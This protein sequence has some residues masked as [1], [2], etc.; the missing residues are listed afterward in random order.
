MGEFFMQ[1]PQTQKPKNKLKTFLGK[2]VL[3]L[4]QKIYE[5]LN[6]ASTK[7]TK[8]SSAIQEVKKLEDPLKEIVRDVVDIL[9]YA[10]A[11]VATYE[12]GDAL[13]VRAFYINP[14]LGGGVTEDKIREWERQVSEFTPKQISLTNPEIARVYPHKEDHKDNLSVIAYNSGNLEISDNLFSLFTPITPK[15][16][17][18]LIN[19]IQQ[20]LGIEQVIAVP[21]FLNTEINGKVE[22]EFIGNLFAAKQDPISIEDQKILSSFA[23]YAALS[24]LS[25]RQ[26]LQV[27]IVEDLI[28]DI[29]KNLT[30]EKRVLKR[31][32]QGIVEEMGY[33]GAMVATYESGDAL[34]VQAM[35]INA[36]IGEIA[37]EDKIKEWEIQVSEFASKPIS[38]TDPEIARVYPHQDEYKGNLSVIAY[39][40]KKPEISDN[41]FSLFTP[42]TPKESE[43][44]INVIQQTLGIKQVIAVPFFLETETSEGIEK[45]FVGNLF[46]LSKS[47]RVSSW[48]IKLLE[49]FGQ[50]AAA[51]LR[52]V[53][54]YHETRELY[55]KA[56]DRRKAAEIFGKMAFTASASVHALKNHMG[57]INGT[58]QIVKETLDG[59]NKDMTNAAIKRM[60]EMTLLVN[61]LHEPWKFQ[62]ETGTDVN[63]C[64]NRATERSLGVDVPW[65]QKNLSSNPLLVKTIPEMLTEAFRVLIK[66]ANEAMSKFPER[67]SLEIESKLIDR[68]IEVIIKDHGEGIA[69]E[70]IFKIFEMRFTTKEESGLGFGLFWAKDYIEGLGGSIDVESVVNIGTKFTVRLPITKDIML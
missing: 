26:R 11:M 5:L 16:S 25:E 21:F 68:Y 30:D 59:D 44:L 4:F 12:P 10:G 28:L 3:W 27:E 24:I 46:A 8:E 42:I 29:Q 60:K 56:E 64:I 37:S 67:R 38:L 45:K 18:G 31:I 39:E 7:P 35:H 66:N 40:S 43:G 57:V 61:S 2:F 32:V 69:P 63:S 49:A 33:A 53:R 41:L 62:H 20:T 22:S 52:N 55:Q 23:H 1:D 15:E 36:E 54:L 13:P 65:V 17:E 14:E 9:G 70:N 48:E 34:P 50:Q 47:F 6:E 58:L 51:G 19:V